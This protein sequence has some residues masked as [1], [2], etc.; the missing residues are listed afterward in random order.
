MCQY[1]KG[2]RNRRGN[3]NV[4]TPF[5]EA[6]TNYNYKPSGRY[7]DWAG[8]SGTSGGETKWHK[9]ARRNS[10]MYA[11]AVTCSNCCK[12]LKVSS[13]TLFFIF[14]SSIFHIKFIFTNCRQMLGNIMMRFQEDNSSCTPQNQDFL[15][16]VLYQ[17]KIGRGI[18]NFFFSSLD[19]THRYTWT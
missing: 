7:L 6:H 3:Q 12:A 11:P 16:S 4:I 13:A 10:E 19:L 14:L 9:S 1:L 17:V 15:L 2:D 18:L 8:R 5:Y